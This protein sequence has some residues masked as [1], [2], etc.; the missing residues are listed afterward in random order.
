MP[1]GRSAVLNFLS[2]QKGLQRKEQSGRGRKREEEEEE[3]ALLN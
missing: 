3:S 2:V 1:R